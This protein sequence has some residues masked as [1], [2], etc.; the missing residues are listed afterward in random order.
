MSSTANADSVRMMTSG[1]LMFGH[2]PATARPPA[3]DAAGV[4]R[5]ETAAKD[6]KHADGAENRQCCERN[7]QLLP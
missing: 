3:L 4:A 1:G 5:A 2:A 6:D 7:L